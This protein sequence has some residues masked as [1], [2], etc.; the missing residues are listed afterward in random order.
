[1]MKGKISLTALF[2]IPFICYSSLVLADYP[3][4]CPDEEG[5]D[6][7]GFFKCNCTSYAAYKI[8]ENGISRFYNT[9]YRVQSPERWGH[10]GFWGEVA[11]DVGIPVDN[12]PKAGD[13]AYWEYQDKYDVGHVAYVESVNSSK[14]T[15]IISEYNYKSSSN[16][17]QELVYGTRTIKINDPDGYI[18]FPYP[19]FFH[20]EESGGSTSVKIEWY[21]A[22]KSCVD[23]S[24]RF[25]ND[26]CDTRPAEEICKE[27]QIGLSGFFWKYL[28]GDW[29]NIFLGHSDI[30]KYVERVGSCN[31]DKHAD[32]PD[33]TCYDF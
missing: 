17:Y 15:V 28:S 11:E 7:W 29:T 5:T 30:E 1:M 8:T 4:K 2:A 14:K 19:K 25:Y 3:Y 16:N 33:V 31:I 21:P 18:H 22:D 26:T 24:I 9:T 13:I 12:C 6:K 32:K 27:A 20:I 23:A 10:A